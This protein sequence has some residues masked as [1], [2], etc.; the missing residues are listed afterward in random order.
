VKVWADKNRGAKTLAAKNA[1]DCC[2]NFLLEFIK[3]RFRGNGSKLMYFI[4]TI[5][6]FFHLYPK[7]DLKV[8]SAAFKEVLF[9]CHV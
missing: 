7:T 1:L 5:N 4:D 8:K 2:K 6:Y 9:L 3:N